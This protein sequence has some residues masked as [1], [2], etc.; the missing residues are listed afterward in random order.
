[1]SADD[2]RSHKPLVL[3]IEDDAAIRSV[4]SDVLEERGLRVCATSNGAEALDA[5]D[6][7]QPDVVV[8]DLLMPVMHGWAFM[9]TYAEK[10]G[11]AH[12]PIIV[13]SVNPVLPRSYDR[14][15]VQRCIAKPFVVEE[16]VD[17]VESALATVTA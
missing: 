1:V 12:I 3:V 17:A 5:L 7:V 15:G 16:L 6:L 9:E 2:G 14:F 10:T 8:L 4:I 11:G 13:V